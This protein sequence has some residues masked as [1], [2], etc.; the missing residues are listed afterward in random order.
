M[1][2]HALSGS[3]RF[4]AAICSR[5]PA[6]SMALPKHG[7]SRSASGPR[8]HHTLTLTDAVSERQ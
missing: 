8:F 5:R 1:I 6:V 2:S 4:L 7:T 3:S